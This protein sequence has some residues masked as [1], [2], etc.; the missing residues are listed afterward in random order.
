MSVSHQ[1]GDKIFHL[2]IVDRVRHGKRG[3]W[4]WKCECDCGS[5][6][7]IYTNSSYFRRGVVKSCGCHSVSLNKANL[8]KKKTVGCAVCGNPYTRL[9]HKQKTCSDDC[10]FKMHENAGSNELCWEWL[11]N[12]N[13]QGYGVLTRLIGAE[14]KVVQ[15]HRAAYEK[16]H[17]EIPPSM[18]VMH[19]CDNRSC[20][21]PSH[22]SVGTWGDNNKDRSD[23]GR[24]G[25]R[26]YSDDEKKRYSSMLAGEGN[27]TSKL[28]N[29]LVCSIRNDY[30]ELSGAAVARLLGLSRSTVNNIRRR[31]TWAHI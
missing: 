3:D 17:G 25:A 20:V 11:G 13:N 22:L 14:K 10:R 6:K 26:I 21:N 9:S 19:S 27:P 4:A 2:T 12:K 1:I 30:P 8:F 5:G 23:K 29:E 18:C 28:T 31:K 7:V 24:S 16:A 15:A